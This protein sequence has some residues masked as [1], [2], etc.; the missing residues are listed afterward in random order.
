MCFQTCCCALL[1]ISHLPAMI[2]RQWPV[3][4]AARAIP[5]L[6]SCGQGMKGMQ[7]LL[8]AAGPCVCWLCVVC[9][10]VCV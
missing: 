7:V 6:L 4:A 1:L 8:H 2:V 9:V 10:C 3:H 5:A